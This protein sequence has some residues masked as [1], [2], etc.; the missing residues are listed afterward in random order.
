MEDF[1][2]FNTLLVIVLF[3]AMSNQT[4]CMEEAGGDKSI[5]IPLPWYFPEQSPYI[6]NPL[7][8]TAD[9]KRGSLEHA[10]IDMVEGWHIPED[11][12]R[13]SNCWKPEELEND[14]ITQRLKSAPDAV[15]QHAL[16][17]TSHRL[18]IYEDSSSRDWYRVACCIAAGATGDDD[19]CYDRGDAVFSKEVL[20]RKV[21]D[22]ILIKA[23]RLN[24]VGFL[25]TLAP[26]AFRANPN[27]LVCPGDYED[28]PNVP[29][30]FMAKNTDMAH[31][32]FQLGAQYTL[33]GA[34]EELA[35][36]HFALFDGDLS[37]YYL[38]NGADPCAENAE[39]YTP[40]HVLAM[41]S[42]D[43]EGNEIQLLTV[44]LSFLL[45]GADPYKKNS[46]G[47]SALELARDARDRHHSYSS[48]VLVKLLTAGSRDNLEQKAHKI[49][50]EINALDFYKE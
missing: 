25:S 16:M 34:P 35:V 38:V 7:T 23:V 31:I 48:A 18:P 13:E 47:E 8:R 32:L 19:Y 14:P 40:L 15:R 41:G 33:R 10:T 6:Y 44:A 29:L 24:K 39:G 30:F 27:I 21:K 46:A 49:E 28:D 36:L 12:D 22:L 11:L 5:Y 9:V 50:V 26:Y 42:P 20:Q 37:A 1:Q 4:F 45:A 3:I 43:Y 17:L 2:R